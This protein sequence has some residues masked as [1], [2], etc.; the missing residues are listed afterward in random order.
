MQQEKA[1]RI[2]I[3]LPPDMLASIKNE[4]RSGSYGSVS[5][6]IREAMRLWQK[7]E[8]EHKARLS[9]LR[10]RLAHAEKSGEPVPLD[11]AFKTIEALHE[12]RLEKEA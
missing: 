7:R 8:D 4:V 2:T 5:E 6:L 12:K 11:A 10:E 1:E 9:L 3:T